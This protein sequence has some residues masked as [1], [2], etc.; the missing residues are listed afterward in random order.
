MVMLDHGNDAVK[1]MKYQIFLLLNHNSDWSIEQ[2]IDPWLYGLGSL[3]NILI[4]QLP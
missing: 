3:D 4:W 2:I 1:I